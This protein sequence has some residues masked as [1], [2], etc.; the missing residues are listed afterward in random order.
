VENNIYNLQLHELLWLNTTN[1]EV[2]RVAGGWLY[3]IF[4]ETTQKICLHQT[5]VPF[6]NEFVGVQM[7]KKLIDEIRLRLRGEHECPAYWWGCKLGR[8]LSCYCYKCIWRFFPSFV[9]TGIMQFNGWCIN[10][11][12]KKMLNKKRGL[13]A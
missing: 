9:L 10:I 8:G 12:F 7:E 2:M 5:F 6:N 3:R 4:D 13:N 11:H 1:T